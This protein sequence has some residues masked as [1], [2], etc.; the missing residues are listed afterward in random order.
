MAGLFYV[1]G[2]T[3]GISWIAWITWIRS[4]ESILDYFASI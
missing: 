3:S 4:W 1:S 2:I